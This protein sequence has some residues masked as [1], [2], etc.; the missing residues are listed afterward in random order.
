MNKCHKDL[1]FAQIEKT[2]VRCPDLEHAE[3]MIA[4]IEKTKKRAILLEVKFLVLQLAFR[5]VGESPF[6]TNY[7]Q[8]WKARGHAQYQCSPWF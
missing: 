4:E 1:D 3:K 2:A 6:L 7:M 8:K 5:L